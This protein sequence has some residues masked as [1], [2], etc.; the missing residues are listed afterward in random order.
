MDLWTIGWLFLTLTRQPFSGR[1]YSWPCFLGAI[2][3]LWVI[4]TMPV[5]ILLN[6]WSLMFLTLDWTQSW[7]TSLSWLSGWII[8]AFPWQYACFQ[9]LEMQPPSK[10]KG[11]M[12]MWAGLCWGFWSW[13]YSSMDA[14]SRKCSKLSSVRTEPVQ[15]LVRPLLSLHPFEKA[16]K[17][18]PCNSLLFLK[19]FHVHYPTQFT[20]TLIENLVEEI[21]L[22]SKIIPLADG[23]SETKIYVLLF[24]ILAIFLHSLPLFRYCYKNSKPRGAEF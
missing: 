8:S 5:T 22:S 18:F 3:S 16:E 12:C 19:I 4:T 10:K 17:C 6:G 7:I 15:H 24:P 1:L 9:W 20:T 14:C 13:K 23:R 11:V 21:L 2:Y